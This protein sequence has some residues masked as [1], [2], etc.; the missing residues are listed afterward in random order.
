MVHQHRSSL[1]HGHSSSRHSQHIRVA[2]NAHHDEI[3]TLNSRINILMSLA[4][5]F[6]CPFVYNALCSV[7]HVNFMSCDQ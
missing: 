5:M 2:P 1:H 3:C 7:P 4:R 6:I